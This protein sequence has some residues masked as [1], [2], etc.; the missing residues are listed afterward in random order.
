LRRE[1][2]FTLMDKAEVF[3]RVVEIVKKEKEIK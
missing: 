2:D 1:K 3:D